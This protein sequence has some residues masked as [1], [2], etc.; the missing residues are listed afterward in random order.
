MQFLE[1]L[2]ESMGQ[3]VKFNIGLVCE[4]DESTAGV[5]WHLGNIPFI[6]FH[7]VVVVCL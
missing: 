7:L 4:G 2:A 5:K 1:Q 6:L 3:N